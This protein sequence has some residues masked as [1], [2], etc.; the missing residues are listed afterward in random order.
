MSGW[1]GF[2]VGGQAVKAVLVD[3]GGAIVA[4]AQHATGLETEVQD[5]GD[6]IAA[7]LASVIVAFGAVSLKNTGPWGASALA[8]SMR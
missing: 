5:L 1:A 4:R 3:D 2:D 6:A 7:V 8:A